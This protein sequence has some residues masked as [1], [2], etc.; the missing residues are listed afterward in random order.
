MADSM[1]RVNMTRRPRLFF[2]LARYILGKTIYYKE[3]KTNEFV[4]L[5]LN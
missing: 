3:T 5:S 2:A 4:L 1:Q